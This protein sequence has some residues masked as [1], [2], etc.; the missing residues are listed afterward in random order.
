MNQPG[1]TQAL[2]PVRATGPDLNAQQQRVRTLILT[3]LGCAS[4]WT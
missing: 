3:R 2:G 4:W 1:G